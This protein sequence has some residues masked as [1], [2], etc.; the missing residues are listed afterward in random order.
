ML[1]FIAQSRYLQEN[2]CTERVAIAFNG[3]FRS[4]PT[5]LTNETE[6]LASS[7]NLLILTFLDTN[8]KRK[9]F[10]R[11]SIQ[12]ALLLLLITNQNTGY[13]LQHIMLC[14]IQP[15][16][17]LSTWQRQAIHLGKYNDSHVSRQTSMQNTGKHLFTT[18]ILHH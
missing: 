7:Y 14:K 1:I 12:S 3:N 17:L 13:I 5:L 16:V 4:H 6:Y 18:R 10:L 9:S 2:T 15:Y 8:S 11:Y